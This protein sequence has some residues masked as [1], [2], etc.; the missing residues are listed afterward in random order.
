LQAECW[1][2]QNNADDYVVPDEDRCMA[3]VRNEEG[4]DTPN[5]QSPPSAMIQLITF[6]KNLYVS[7]RAVWSVKQ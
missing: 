3:E 5:S 7:A 4:N 2:Q 6:I 1:Q